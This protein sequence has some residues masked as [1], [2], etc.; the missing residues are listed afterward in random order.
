MDPL[1]KELQQ[2]PHLLSLAPLIK[3]RNCQVFLVGGFL[4]NLLLDKKD[5]NLDLDFAVSYDALEL[6]RQ[7]SRKIKGFYVVLDRKERCARVIHQFKG[8]AYTLDFA[9]FRGKTIKADLLLR[10]FTINNLAVDIKKLESAKSL[11]E[12]LVDESFGQR[13]LKNRLIRR[14]HKNSFQDDPLRIIRA[15]SLA[16]NLNFKIDG[17]TLTQ[18]KRDRLKLA[19]VAYER[20]RDE[21]FK[22]LSVED[23][24]VY[25]KQMDKLR[26]LEEI[27]PQITVMRNVKQGPY[28]HL[29]VWQHSL[30]TVAQLEKIFKELDS[31][32]DIRKYLKEELVFN[33]S[34]KSLMKLGALLHDI[35]KP[36]SKRRKEGKTLFHGH[37][38][39]GRDISDKISE[40]LKLS[41]KEKLALEKMIFWHLRPGYLADNELPT[42]RAVFRYFRDAQEEGVSILLISLADQRATCGPLTSKKDRQQHERV[43]KDLIGRYFEK[44]KEEKIKRLIDGNDLIGRLKLSPSP[45]FSRILREVE[46]SQAEGSVKTKAQ[47]LALAKKIAASKN[48][49]V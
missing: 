21:L 18:A 30:E 35:G 33:R 37:E 17:T 12:I 13:D 19:D 2:Q 36:Q 22:I 8:K 10:D 16:A 25:L 9:Q 41:T 45:V 43:I 20:I 28:H 42:A 1:L 27:L 23:S 47:A 40:M 4:R 44:Q 3:R 11:G 24:A 26:I 32:Q 6:A 39:V 34:R 31:N 15:F 29:D 38:R 49:P 7:F 5:G 46:E 48:R 14:V